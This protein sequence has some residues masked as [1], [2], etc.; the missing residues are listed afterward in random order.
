MALSGFA[1]LPRPKKRGVTAVKRSFIP[2]VDVH[3]S[4]RPKRKG[5]FIDMAPSVDFSRVE[6]ATSE[7]FQAMPG[8]LFQIAGEPTDDLDAGSLSVV[9]RISGQLPPPKDSTDPSC[10][11]PSCTM[12]DCVDTVNKQ[13]TISPVA[14]TSNSLAE[15]F[16]HVTTKQ[17]I[18]NAL[19][20][21]VPYIDLMAKSA[22]DMAELVKVPLGALLVP[23]QEV[24]LMAKEAAEKTDVT[25]PMFL[26]FV[27]VDNAVRAY[28]NKT[29]SSMMQNNT[30]RPGAVGIAANLTRVDFEVAGQ[31]REMISTRGPVTDPQEAAFGIKLADAVIAA[32][33]DAVG[34]LPSQSAGMALQKEVDALEKKMRSPPSEMAVIIGA[35]LAI[36]LIVGIVEFNRRKA[37]KSAKL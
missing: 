3:P 29:I 13:G 11:P 16:L 6:G 15:L 35:S 32:D 26:K 25:Q 7:Q 33:M 36:L 20:L 28:L 19:T 8:S 21:V 4:R 37:G 5:V 22:Y 10:P 9:R 30:A 31:L 34:S 17:E 14:G 23:L 18:A 24:V 2:G 27:D 12:M 1:H